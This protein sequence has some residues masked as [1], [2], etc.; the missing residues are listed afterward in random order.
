LKNFPISLLLPALLLDLGCSSPDSPGPAGASGSATGGSGATP[1]AGSANAGAGSGLGG[2]GS[3]SGSGSGGA[4]AGASQAGGG[5]SSSAGNA[6]SAGA[7]GA[8]GS[9]GA[10]GAS[11]AGGSGGGAPSTEKFSFFVT[12]MASMLDL[13]KAKDASQTVGF[14]GDFSYGESGAGAGLRG[15]DKICSVIAEKSMPG[16]NKVWRAFLSATKGED[17]QQVN[18]ISRIGAGPWYDRTGRLV[19]TNVAGLITTRPGGDATIAVDLPNE[20]G[21]PNHRPN[22]NEDEVDNHDTLTGSNEQGELDSTNMG[23]TCNDWT[24]KVGSTGVPR[25]GHSWP[26]TAGQSWISE[27]GAG[28]CAPGVNIFGTGGPPPG[29]L[30]VGAGGGYGGIYCFALSP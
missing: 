19:A 3:G 25:V 16:N 22:P 27:H 4:S 18:A 12:S 8:S 2:G 28:G 21:V 26:R 11:G 30:S 13:A 10:A 7:A 23:A 14:G 15:A 9:G 6:G 1:T 5:G 20:D 24:S 17:G 29:D